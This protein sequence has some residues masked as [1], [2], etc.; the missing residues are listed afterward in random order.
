VKKTVDK[1][2]PGPVLSGFVG[3]GK[4]TLLNHVLGNR[5]GPRDAVI[6]NDISEV[7]SIRR[8]SKRKRGP[9][10]SVR[11]SSDPAFNGAQIE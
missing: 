8:P 11:Y 10:L 5:E 1:R 3:A 4:T 9:A 7:K 2:L 6:V